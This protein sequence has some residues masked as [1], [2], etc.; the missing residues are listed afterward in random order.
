[1]LACGRCRRAPPDSVTP[2]RRAAKEN[3]KSND[4]AELKEFHVLRLS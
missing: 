2:P 1:L 3:E 4:E